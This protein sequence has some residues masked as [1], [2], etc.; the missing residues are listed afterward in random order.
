MER[1]TTIVGNVVLAHAWEHDSQLVK[2]DFNEH[3]LTLTET[4]RRLHATD[5]QKLIFIVGSSGTGKTMLAKLLAETG[6]NSQYI[7]CLD[8]S[9]TFKSEDLKHQNILSNPS[10]T[11]L[12]DSPEF[13][14][15]SIWQ[16]V[17]NHIASGGICICFTQDDGDYQGGLDSVFLQLD[18]NGLKEK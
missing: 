15:N 1:P 6:P 14:N 13:L 10:K 11:Y 16:S 18:H 7:N 5:K 9:D 3:A 12:L 2:I 8:L 17:N 4:L